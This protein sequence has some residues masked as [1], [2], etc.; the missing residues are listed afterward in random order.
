MHLPPYDSV[1]KLLR[2]AICLLYA[3]AA[4]RL[5]IAGLAKRYRAFWILAVFYAIR[6]LALF[7]C[8][9]L[10]RPRTA[11]AWAWMTTEPIVWVLY[12]WLALDLYSLVLQDYKGLQTVGR[13]IF[14]IA[15]SLAILASGASVLPN[16]RSPTEKFPI[17][18]YFALINRGKIEAVGTPAELKAELGPGATMDDVFANLTRT[19]IEP[20]GDMRNVRRERRSEHQHS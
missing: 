15:L 11:Y 13:W 6:G 20:E 8:D 16:W 18:F 7:A 3:V 2:V 5:S 4:V 17:V 1:V 9:W 12:V 10:P 19:V 14:L